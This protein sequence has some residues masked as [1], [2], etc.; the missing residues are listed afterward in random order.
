MRYISES[1]IEKSINYFRK[2]DYKKPEQIGLFLYFKALGVNDKGYIEYKKWGS[3]EDSERR[4][5]LRV[6]YD[7][8]GTFDIVSEYGKKR[9]S[10]FPFSI[11]KEIKSTAF[12]NGATV[13]KSLGSR[14]GDT[15]DNAL[16]SSYLQKKATADNNIKLRSDASELIFDKY[17]LKKKIP[18][19]WCAA[20]CFKFYKI[21]LD[22][23]QEKYIH[24][25][26]VLSFLKKYNISKKEFDVLFSLNNQ[27][28]ELSNTC[29][30]GPWL[31]TTINFDDD[32][33][34]E[35]IK[36]TEEDIMPLEMK[37]SSNEINEFIEIVKD[38]PLSEDYI[39]EI[40][41]IWDNER[42]IQIEELHGTAE[43]GE[44]AVQGF[45][46]S[47]DFSIEQ[48][49]SILKK[50]Y[51]G[52]NNV[53]T[54]IHLFGIKY[55]AAIRENGFSAKKIIA[56]SGIPESYDVEINK[57]VRIYEAISNNEFG[58][59][60]SADS[61][62]KVTTSLLNR[63]PR[64]RSDYPL[65]FIVYGAPGTGKTYS[66]AEYATA[67]IENR[68]TDFSKVGDDARKALMDKYRHY[69]KNGQIVFTTFHQNYGYEEF[70]QGLRPDSDSSNLSFRKVDGVFKTIADKA[71][72]DDVNNYVI[73][74]DEINRA[75]IS[76]VFGELI[77]LIEE[78]KR[79]GELNQMSV[80]L[81]SGDEFAVPNNLYII[82]TMNSAD[83]SISLIDVAL[84]RRFEF[85]E[86]K[87][88]ADLIQDKKLQ[89]IFTKINDI[90]GDELKSAD[91]LIGHSYF[92]NKT[93]ADLPRIM[94]NN[95]IPLLYEYYYDDKKKINKLLT[96][97]LKDTDFNVLDNKIGRLSVK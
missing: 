86:Q 80:T 82:G 14:V 56:A 41:N 22:Q 4:N 16:V 90:L 44:V 71:M 78:D 15:L 54:A 59:A 45:E 52:A 55:G 97:A 36:R 42:I 43:L 85:V 68:P 33:S 29:I 31:R 76:K 2:S 9:A 58:F 81:P 38:K 12:Y 35:I 72:T 40:L 13:F 34:P 89:S 32:A 95:I 61:I 26:C 74:I 20:W 10:L 64:T 46:N 84:R 50:M 62:S 96:E 25:I 28:I 66:T 48:L 37:I 7:L 3:T 11:S 70:I 30:T 1:T 87:P 19:E 47:L 94:N 21:E 17:L 69:V 27:E 49:G 24:D 63:K 93:E 60:F 83:K 39:R 65:D 18:I 67:I 73:I 77:T 75:N 51:D 5:M 8:S 57:G 79:W 92:M 23:S 6:L 88:D 91:L 53:T